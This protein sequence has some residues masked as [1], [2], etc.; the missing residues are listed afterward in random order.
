MHKKH[1]S[2]HAIIIEDVVHDGIIMISMR[3]SMILIMLVLIM[4]MMIG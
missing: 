2:V 3:L 1:D 4:M